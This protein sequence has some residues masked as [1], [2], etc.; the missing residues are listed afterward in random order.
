MW[1]WNKTLWYWYVSVRSE[2]RTFGFQLC[3]V[4]W[5]VNVPALLRVQQ[6]TLWVCFPSK[7]GANCW[8]RAQVRNW[9]SYDQT[10]KFVPRPTWPNLKSRVGIFFCVVLVRIVFAQT[11]PRV[12]K[13]MVFCHG[14]AIGDL[15]TF[16][17][18]FSVL[19]CSFSW[20][21]AESSLGPSWQN[22]GHFAS[23][24]VIQTWM[25]WPELLLTLSSWFKPKKYL[26][27]DFLVLYHPSL[28][29]SFFWA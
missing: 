15:S 28:F 26:E 19:K 12:C 11:N 27:I 16:S 7:S 25:N 3:H 21:G 29:L 18:C 20:N 5:G 13:V 22:F 8:S 9:E 2:L 24:E 23:V 4:S 14:V 1:R 10:Q 17:I 6:R